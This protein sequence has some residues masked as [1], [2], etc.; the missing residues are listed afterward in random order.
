MQKKRE[1]FFI[2]LINLSIAAYIVSIFVFSFNE[3]DA[4]LSRYLFIPMFVLLTGYVFIYQKGKISIGSFDRRFLAFI[5][6]CLLS[7]IFA[8]NRGY[9]VSKCLTLL[10]IFAMCWLLREYIEKEEKEDFFIFTLWLGST[11]LVLYVIWFYGTANVLSSIVSG[12]RI[13]RDIT[14]VNMI[15]L[16]A[17]QGAC[18]NYWYAYYK[19][20]Y[21]AYA[22]VAICVIV[23]FASGSRKSLVCL[24]L[25]ILALTLLKGN[26]IK[27]I[28]YFGLGILILVGV[29]IAFSRIPGLEG[30]HQRIL[31]MFAAFTRGSSADASSIHRMQYIEIGMRQFW[32]NP[33]IGVGI[34]NTRTLLA[35][36]MGRDTYLHN[37]YVE[38]LASV[39]I[40]GTI[41][42]YYLL[43]KPVVT[44]IR[45]T[46]DQRENV[47]LALVMLLLDL[48][49]Q[50]GQVRYYHK[51]MY[52]FVLLAYIVVKNINNEKRCAVSS[53]HQ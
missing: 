42:F 27:K 35:G 6:V 48:I 44:L 39:G 2:K 53:S 28:K 40:F 31:A 36:A 19:K 25:G 51:E 20:K 37:N 50:Y 24:L 13:G 15:G 23:V 11:A 34:G 46:K 3:E 41:V 33:F 17:T 29:Y 22:I 26:G 16:C 10:Q 4:I 30:I 1:S 12:I 45:H 5:A 38:L 52:L 47:F 49:F 8:V 21:P 32:Q 18:I 14:N 9:A 7:I 43:G